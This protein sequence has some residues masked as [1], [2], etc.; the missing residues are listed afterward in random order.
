MSAPKKHRNGKRHPM[1]AS[2]RPIAKRPTIEVIR[3]L[4]PF[5]P[6]QH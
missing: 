2:S 6:N 4:N 1:D 3:V 5:N